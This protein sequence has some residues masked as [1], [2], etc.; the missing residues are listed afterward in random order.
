MAQYNRGKFTIKREVIAQPIIVLEKLIPSFIA[1]TQARRFGK[2]YRQSDI[3]FMMK[4][5]PENSTIT[6]DYPAYKM[7]KFQSAHD[8]YVY[9]D[10]IE[11]TAQFLKKII[12]EKEQKEIL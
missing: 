5:L 8:L 4:N 10:N 7:T 2:S 3:N 11:K 12:L 6:L 1:L 9:V